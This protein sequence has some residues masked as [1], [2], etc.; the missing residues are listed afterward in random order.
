[1]GQDQQKIQEQQEQRDNSNFHGLVSEISDYERQV[2]LN[3]IQKSDDKK[4]KKSDGKDGNSGLD[5][6]LQ[7][8]LAKVSLI[9]RIIFWIKASFT[10]TTVEGVFNAYLLSKIAV[11]V[12]RHYKLVI[13]YKRSVLSSTFYDKLNLLRNAAEFFQDAIDLYDQKPDIFYSVLGKV[14]MPDVMDEIYNV[15]DPYQY[16]FTKELNKEMRLNLINKM[17]RVEDN[18][19]QNNRIDMYAAVRSMEWLKSFVNLPY[20][21]FIAKF[22][23]DSNGSRECPF[24]QCTNEVTAF[25]RVFCEPKPLTEELLKA[26]EMFIGNKKRDIAIKDGEVTFSSFQEEAAAQISIINT[27]IEGINID[28]VTKLVV[29]NSVYKAEPIAGGEDWLI[30]FKTNQKTI[31]DRRWEEWIHEYKKQKIKIKLISYFSIPEFPVF[32]YRPWTDLWDGIVFHYELSLGF[33]YNFFKIVYPDYERVLKVI[34]LEGDF[35]VK[36]NRIEYTDSLNELNQMYQDLNLLATQLTSAGEFGQAFAKFKGVHTKSKTTMERVDVLMTDV[37]RITFSLISNFGKTC[38][39]LEN[40]LLGMT[41]EKI[42]PYYGPLTN[43]SKIKGG[44]NKE[45]RESL[46]RTKNGLMHAFELVK[47]LEPLDKEVD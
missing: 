13:N 37:E 27:F 8:Q 7:E 34:A 24:T 20:F 4:H 31:F 29:G 12:E 23:M 26:I 17:E 2:L 45:F 40:L 18:I 14:I 41:G 42:S 39:S 32:P 11:G 38:R 5:N 47:D 33:L 6:S 35:S 25:S 43:L 30:K 10:G 22:T 19:P 9:Q 28:L 46:E 36:E 21:R 3:R 44:D 1:M 15:S 16:P